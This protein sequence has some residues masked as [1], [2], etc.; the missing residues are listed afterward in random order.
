MI[1]IGMIGVNVINS[2]NSSSILKIKYKKRRN[3]KMRRNFTKI[4]IVK[5]KGSDKKMQSRLRR[6][7]SKRIFEKN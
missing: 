5:I 4:A 1:I 7:T 3:V 6:Q 2:S